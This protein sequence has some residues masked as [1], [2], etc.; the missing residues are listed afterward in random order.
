MKPTTGGTYRVMGTPDEG[1]KLLLIHVETHDPTYVGTEGYEGGL[2]ESVE[3]LRPGYVIDATLELTDDTA[4][5]TEVD[6]RS[7]TL[8]EFVDG[9]TGIFEAAR[10]TW[11]EARTEGIAVNSDVTY[12]TDGGA[13]GAVYTFAKQQGARDVW[14]EL[15]TGILPLEPLIERLDGEDDGPH[16]V[17]VM[18]PADEEFV[19][20]YL[21]LEKD[22]V[23]A[24]T[25]RDTYDCPRSPEE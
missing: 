6:V 19:L 13:N 3:G 1:G 25:V 21:V 20:V 18:R 22:S 12:D 5:F 24:D 15:R 16:E 2:R 23:L 9:A 4:A 10:E 7:R 8:V 11:R 14:E 17:F